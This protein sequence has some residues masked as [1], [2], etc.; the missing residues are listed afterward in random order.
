MFGAFVLAAFLLAGAAS[1]SSAAGLL[2]ADGGLGGV[3]EI[4]QHEVNVTINN[5]VA[6]TEVTQ[7]FRNTESRQVEALYTFPV[8]KDASVANFSMW[9]NGKEM[10]GE[11]VEKQRARQIYDSYKAKRIDPGLLE[12]TDYKTFE[13][14]IFP[15]N[16]GAEQKVQ[17]CYYQ[18]LD[19]DHDWGTYVYPLAT[20]S[21]GGADSRTAGKFALT[22]HAK[23]EVPIVAMDSPS[24]R[25]DFV[26][27]R[28]A[29]A[30][31][32]AGLETAGGDL[33]RDVVLAYRLSRPRTGIDLIASRHGA[34]DGYFCLTLTA[35]KELEGLNSSMD[36]AF[37]LDISGSMADAGKLALSRET[38]GA[39]IQALQEED[40]FE[41][42]TF[43][44]AAKALFDQLRPADERN[45]AQASDFLGSQQARGG[46]VLRP[47]LEAAY[48]YASPD[49]TL[50]VVIL[51]DGMTEQGERAALIQ[52]IR[53]RPA[54]VRVFCVGVGNEVNRP[55]LEQLAEDSG[56]LAAFLSRGDDFQR[57]AAAFRRKLTRPVL[58]DLQIEFEGPQVYDREPAELPN[59]YHGT[60]LRLYGRYRQPGPVKVKLR[61]LI[62]GARFDNTVE[63]TFPAADRNNG[64]IGRMWA[65]HKVHRLLKGADRTGSRA[66][67]I[68]AV[69]TL[70]EA[71]SIA[72][73]HTSF[74]VLENDAQYKRWKIERRNALRL[75]R[76][77]SSQQELQAQLESMRSRAS[78]RLGPQRAAPQNLGPVLAAGDRPG[79][80]QPQPEPADRQVGRPRGRDLRLPGFG[81]GAV[82][83]I[84]AA[85]LGLWAAAEWLRRR[86]GRKCGE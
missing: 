23:S 35:G 47:A 41:I 36:Y 27:A 51:S 38:V 82:G 3:L 70:G 30:Y 61:G 66:E 6:V 48:R 63:L 26:F 32:Q 54:N 73:E 31:W 5:G 20:V 15:V 22:V 78:A 58:T 56:G 17:I 39:F 50:N 29:D 55:L 64:E 68:P 59:L 24:H 60:P 84:G 4:Q 28:H 57:Q 45:K 52:Q 42:I 72:T 74:I 2:I 71:Y 76:D 12:Q 79:Q 80:P 14:R 7:V 83:P 62:R 81:G 10:V 49:R 18:E 9:I 46:T 25:K 43:N 67:V 1:I 85:A 16:A 75:Q 44:V 65:W 19:F 33:N 53:S 40:R 86:K 11:V 77:R 37:I 21:A 8:P 34:E 69:V 13:M